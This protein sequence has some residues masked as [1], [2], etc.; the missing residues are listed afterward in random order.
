MVGMSY[1][2]TRNSFTSGSLKGNNDI[3]IKKD[4][5]LFW[6]LNYGKESATKGVGG[7][8]TNN[9]KLS[10]FGRVSYEYDNFRSKT[11][12]ATSPQCQQDGPSPTKNSLKMPALMWTT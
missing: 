1:S 5:P 9:S 12:G 3:A 7:D 4:D 10:Y 2:E 8:R 6:F 11:A